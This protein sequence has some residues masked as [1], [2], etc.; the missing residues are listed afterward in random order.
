[1]PHLYPIGREGFLDG[2]IDWDTNTQKITLINIDNYKISGGSAHQYYGKSVG[3]TARVKES[4]TNALSTKT[5]T[6]GI[7]DAGDVSLSAVS[8]AAFNAIIIW[9]D[10]GSP[11]TS[12]LIAYI[13]SGT[14]LPASPNSGDITI[15]WSNGASKIFQL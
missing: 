7:A 1:M 8:G 14:G 2:S 12:R 10:S 6:S 11:D 5:V 15:S 3:I 13:D 4:D 9:Q